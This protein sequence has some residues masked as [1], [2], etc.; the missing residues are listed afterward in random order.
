MVPAGL[1]TLRQGV[2]VVCGRASRVWYS[3]RFPCG[4]AG[5]GRGGQSGM[6]WFEALCFEDRR[7]YARVPLGVKHGCGQHAVAL[8]QKGNSV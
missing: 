6:I 5:A 7:V 2:P 3:I 4:E 8:R 1:S